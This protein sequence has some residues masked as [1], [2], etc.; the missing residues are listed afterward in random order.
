[1]RLLV[2]GI[3]GSIGQTLLKVLD[4]H[5][6]VGVSFY[7]HT[8]LAQTIIEKYNVPF[9]WSPLHPQTSNVTSLDE[10]IKQTK[11]DLIVNAVTGYAGLT[12]SLKAIEHKIDLALANKE[13]LVMAGHIIMPLIKQAKIHLYP[14]DSEHSAM[15]DLLTKCDHP[16]KQ[17]YIT[18]SGGSCYH[19][20]AS[21]RK[22]ITYQQVIKHPN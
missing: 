1:M 12:Y 3:T 18:C 11:P 13:S 9:Y 19:L 16:I 4:Q 21:Q 5:Q 2:F 14:I 22:A 7:Q 20:S 6:L 17:L 15:A 10:L 8:Q